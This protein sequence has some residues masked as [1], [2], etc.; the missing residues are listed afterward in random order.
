ML[1]GSQPV[2]QD[3]QTA[4]IQDGRLS[5][6]QDCRNARKQ[7]CRNDGK[8]DSLLSEYPACRMDG[9]NARTQSCLNESRAAVPQGSGQSIIPAGKPGSYPARKIAR[10]QD[11][12]AESL[13]D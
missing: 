2:L 12:T 8:R 3:E 11:C 9:M 4:H 6:L 7:E 5:C 13:Q 1:A 10:N